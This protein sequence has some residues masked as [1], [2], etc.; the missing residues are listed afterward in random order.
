MLPLI[1][2]G[3]QRGMIVWD[4]ASTHQ[5][6][7]MKKFLVERRID[8]IM[9]PAGMTAYLQTL[10]ITINKPFKDH[11]CKEIN[12]YIKNRMIRNDCGNFVK[13]KLEKIVTWVANSWNKITTSLTVAVLTMH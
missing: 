8:Q 7:D 10:D 13:P 9:I 5:A 2:Q 6:K 3:S 11:L 4:S 1:L 12:D